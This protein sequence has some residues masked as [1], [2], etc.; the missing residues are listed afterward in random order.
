MG[1]AGR[2]LPTTCGLCTRWAAVCGCVEGVPP[3]VELAVTGVWRQVR[4]S[5]AVSGGSFDR[6]DKRELIRFGRAAARSSRRPCGY[7]SFGCYGVASSGARAGCLPEGAYA[8]RAGLRPG[9]FREELRRGLVARPAS[10][11]LDDLL[12]LLSK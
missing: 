8:F 10:A 5:G 12:G 6:I 9:G 2:G 1:R 11:E 4:R 7:A 3:H